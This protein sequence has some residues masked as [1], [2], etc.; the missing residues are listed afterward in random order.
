[1]SYLFFKNLFQ[2][3]KL[4]LFSKKIKNKKNPKTHFSGFFGGF[5]RWVFLGGFFIA[6]PAWS[7]LMYCACSWALHQALSASAKLLS[8]PRSSANIKT[9]S[10]Q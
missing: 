10:H 2:K 4:V 6:N 7:R 8:T 5:F 9:L 1:M 3:E